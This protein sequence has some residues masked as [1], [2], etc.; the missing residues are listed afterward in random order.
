MIS[1]KQRYLV[2]TDFPLYMKHS[3]SL[4]FQVHCIVVGANGFLCDKTKIPGYSAFLLLFQLSQVFVNTISFA[5]LFVIT[6]QRENKSIS[7][8]TKS[9]TKGHTEQNSDEYLST[10]I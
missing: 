3:G 2:H 1:T 6:Q 10:E 9:K 5:I 4:L 7:F 8:P